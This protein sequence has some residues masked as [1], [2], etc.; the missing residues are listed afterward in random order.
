LKLVLLDADVI[1]DLFRL[2]L[3]NQVINNISIVIPPI[4]SQ[5]SYYYLNES[6][7]KRYFDLTRYKDKI[8]ILGGEEVTAEN[9]TIIKN[10][11]DAYNTGREIHAGELE[12]LTIIANNSDYLFCTTDTAAIFALAAL[13]LSERGKSLEELLKSKSI[14]TKKLEYKHTKKKF[15]KILVEGL[16]FKEDLN[17]V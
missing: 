5:E 13:G 8:S 17:N 15:R 4:I 10:K 2:G 14:S 11:F 12:A 3:W 1:I 7:I 9:I 6:G 16:L